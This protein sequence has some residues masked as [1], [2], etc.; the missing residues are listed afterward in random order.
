MT[1]HEPATLATDYLLALLSGALAWHLRHRAPRENRTQ[2]WWSGVLALTAVSAFIGGSY[3][4]FAPNFSSH[5]EAAWWKLT[6][7]IVCFVATAM[8]LSLL[9]ECSP[10]RRGWRIAIGLKLLVFVLAALVYPRF[11]VAI[12]AYGMAMFAWLGASLT[13]RRPWRRGM[14]AAIVLSIVGAIVQQA[15]LAPSPHFNHNDLYHVLQAVA[16]VGFHRA[17]LRLGL[18]SATKNGSRDTT[19]SASPSA[20]S[21]P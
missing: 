18:A 14:L 3:H 7:I 11:V 5:V 15:R 12:A 13:L 17:G 4:G 1:L 10:R 6:L 8:E 19:T 20:F 21:S 16:L 2:R 9:H